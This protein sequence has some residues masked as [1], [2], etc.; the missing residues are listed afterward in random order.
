MKKL[1]SVKWIA[2]I[3]P[4]LSATRP[5]RQVVNYLARYT[6]LALTSIA[7]TTRSIW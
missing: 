1:E 7:H 3:Q 6:Y 5:A 4:P 2:Y